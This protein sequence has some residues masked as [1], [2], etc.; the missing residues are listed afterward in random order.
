[1]MVNGIGKQEFCS[2]LKLAT[3]ESLFMFNKHYYRQNDWVAMRSP[4]GP[5]LANI[6]LCQHEEQWLES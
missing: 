2:L 5:T 1:M 4:L 6:L 3:R